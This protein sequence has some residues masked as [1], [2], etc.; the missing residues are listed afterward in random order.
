MELTINAINKIATLYSG[1]PTF[2]GEQFRNQYGKRYD[3]CFKLVDK[4]EKAVLL[5]EHNVVD[6]CTKIVITDSTNIYPNNYKIVQIDKMAGITAYVRRMLGRENLYRKNI[7]LELFDMTLSRV[8]SKTSQPISEIFC[9]YGDKRLLI[10]GSGPS[11]AGIE[12]DRI[13]KDVD[14]MVINYNFNT[15]ADWHFYHDK[16][17]ATDLNAV[18]FKDKRKVIGPKNRPCS[19]QDYNFTDSID[20]IKTGH[21][22]ATALQFGQKMGYREI[23]LAGYDYMQTEGKDHLYSDTNDG[24]YKDSKQMK[25]FLSDFQ[26]FQVT[27]NVYNLNNH[28]AL[29]SIKFTNKEKVYAY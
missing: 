14:I 18:I 29:K 28:S 5:F 10:M 25:L 19:I 9:K 2:I 11:C 20:G 15:R 4:V 1:L 17:V 8:G 22:G 23:Y 7:N 26:K 3:F 27:D 12:Y 6:F 24:V 16:K 21:S 13:A